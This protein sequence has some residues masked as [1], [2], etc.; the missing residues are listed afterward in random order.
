MLRAENK[1]NSLRFQ[2]G[3]RLTDSRWEGEKSKAKQHK[4]GIF[5]S[6]RGCIFCYVRYGV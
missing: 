6:H 5:N 3:T 2:C 4:S 1:K